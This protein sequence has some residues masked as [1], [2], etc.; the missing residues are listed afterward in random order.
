[1]RS[2]SISQAWDEAKAILVHDGRLFVSVALALIVLPQTILGAAGIGQPGEAAPLAAAVLFVGVLIGFAAQIALNRLAL[3]PHITVGAAIGRGF[4]RLLPLF[5]ALFLVGLALVLALILIGFVLAAMGVI[6][7]PVKGQP[8]SAGLLVLI[9]LG[10]A[11]V[12]A[13]FQLLVPL[14]AAENGGPIRLLSRSWSIARGN[15][16]RLLL[17]VMIILAAAL[18]VLLASQVVIGSAVVL[19]LGKPV[20]GSVSALVFALLVAL[21]QSAVTVVGS[22]MLARI[23]V[24]LAG[25]D[26]APAGVPSTGI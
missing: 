4:K 12:S 18:I 23:Y 21:I 22:V 5:V 15:Y 25:R 17:F 11:T 19:A 20:A 10:I 16:G 6:G 24:Q 2:L 9:V 3:G 8:P 7:M 1:M 13:I 26:E 14:A